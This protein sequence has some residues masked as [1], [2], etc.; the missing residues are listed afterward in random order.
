MPRKKPLSMHPEAIKSR[1]YHARKKAAQTAKPAQSAPA[2][3]VDIEEGTGFSIGVEA[4]PETTFESKGV[5]QDILGAL[6]LSKQSATPG[7]KVPV[8]LNKKQQEFCDNVTPIGSSVLI[9]SL[10]WAWGRLGDPY[11][12]CAPDE[13]VATRIVEPLIRIYARQAKFIE[14]LDPNTA[15][16]L[17]SL[18]ATVGY[19][20]TSLTMFDMIT[21]QLREQEE[22]QNGR[23]FAR[24]YE[25]ANSG[26]NG[27]RPDTEPSHDAAREQVVSGPPA[28]NLDHL[29]E[30][31]RSS[32]EALSK[33][34][35]RDIAARQRRSGQY[36]LS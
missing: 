21:A 30:R 5:L 31:E 9:A 7:K 3:P 12:A 13:A 6:G 19:G 29:S 8:N 2:A 18:S 22:M 34:R 20:L 33:L 24:A 4:A 28:V 27:R 26:T 10:A 32:Y 14:S 1:E 11:R 23:G 35:D 25:S 16:W 15:D 17:A 36:G